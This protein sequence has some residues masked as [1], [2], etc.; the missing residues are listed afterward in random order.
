VLYLLLSLALFGTSVLGH[1]GSRVI[2][3][4]QIDSSQFMWFFA[5]WP[6]AVLHGLNPFVSH[7]MFA[8]EGVNLT[9][10]AAMPG[11][12]IL[13]APVTLTAGPIVSWNV[14]ELAAPALSAWTAFLLCRHVTGRVG[15]SLA[16][17][18]VFGFSPY[19]LLNLTGAPNLAFT[20]LIPVLVWLVLRHVEG[21]IGPRGFVVATAV[22]LAAQLSISTEVLATATLFG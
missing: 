13:L 12:S 17:G 5:W 3:A 6:H 4:D 1:L 8:P 11:P 14:I 7:A 19:M 18:Y 22:A 9:W 20:A 15:P 10:S 16:G 2:A 21:R